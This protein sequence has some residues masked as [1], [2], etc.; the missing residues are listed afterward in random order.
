MHHAVGLAEAR[1]LQIEPL[2]EHVEQPAAVAEQDVDHVDPDLVAFTPDDAENLR[3]T[4]KTFPITDHYDV[5]E[6]LTSLGIGEAFVTVLTP[7]GVPTPLAATRLVPP[8][9][10]MDAVDEATRSELIAAGALRERYA[11]PVDRE[12]AHEILTQAPRGCG[13]RDH[14]AAAAPAAAAR[15]RRDGAAAT[16]G[17]SE[18]EGAAEVPAEGEGRGVAR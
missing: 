14:V 4:V 12:S 6:T 1:Q 8:D 5:G 9:S 10:L 3:K 17:G 7:K 15:S 13:D 16:Q 2:G 18:D 11:T